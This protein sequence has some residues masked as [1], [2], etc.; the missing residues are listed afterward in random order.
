MAKD[1]NQLIIRPWPKMIFLWPSCLMSLFMGLGTL[2][3]DA[4]SLCGGVFLIV[5]ALNLVV[6]TFEFPR[7]TSLLVTFGVI[8]VV[9]GLVMI[10]YMV[11]PI[12]RPL[13]DFLKT[14]DV[15]ASPQFYYLLFFVQVLLF[16]GM[17]VIT[18]FE[19]WVLTPNEL[20]RHHGLLGDVERFSTA[21]LKLN[22]EIQDVFEYVLAGAGRVVMNVPG[23]PRPIILD[24][25]L[26][27][28]KVEQRSDK[29]LNARVVRLEKPE[30]SE[31]Q[32]AAYHEG[33]TG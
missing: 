13:N 19:Y 2:C 4:D 33:E 16:C 15:Q 18:R 11:F 24:N 9:M 23:N 27:I 6:L 31:D 26:N 17:W 10:N 28:S 25:V 30:P 21:G 5:L 32:N 20:V 29:I 1:D 8:I 7:A 14:L 22:K 3:S 12:I